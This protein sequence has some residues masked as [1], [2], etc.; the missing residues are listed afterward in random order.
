MHD[1]VFG[2]LR[3]FLR[4]NHIKV[5]ER[6][7]LALLMALEMVSKV[8]PTKNVILI[9]D[10]GGWISFKNYPLLFN[11]EI[12]EVKTDYGIIDLE[13]LSKNAK[14]ASALLITFLAGYF[15]EQP[16]KEISKICK[17]NK[18]LLVE[19]ATGAIGDNILC[20]GNFSDIIIGSFGVKDIVN[21]GY[22]GFIAFR[23]YDWVNYIKIS[24]SL[25]KV[26]ERIY[27]DILVKLN[28][29]RLNQLFEKAE[30]VKNE[31]EDFEVIHRN[32]R[33]LNVV[34]KFTS[35]IIKY[36]DRNNYP[37][38]L[39]PEYTRVNESAISIELKNL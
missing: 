6:G 39:C 23:E 30:K 26:H 19:D 32:K 21:L 3:E 34:V 13:S 35:E 10:Q 17:E 15:A 29:N 12:R 22:G 4:L 37:Y 9:P 16:L 7:N 14:D 38:I 33:G 28:R 25:S 24:S 20:N 36:C 5:V 11:F 27:F 8:N 31:L 2:R 18:C 1:K